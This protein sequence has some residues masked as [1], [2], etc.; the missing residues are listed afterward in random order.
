MGGRRG[1]TMVGYVCRPEAAAGQTFFT[2]LW[3]EQVYGFWDHRGRPQKSGDVE[4]KSPGQ[5]FLTTLWGDRN[6]CY[7]V[8]GLGDPKSLSR[9]LQLRWH[10]LLFCSPSPIDSASY[11]TYKKTE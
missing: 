6:R 5:T 2:A 9:N 4:Y 3:E 1:G 10:C 8:L 11:Y 7:K